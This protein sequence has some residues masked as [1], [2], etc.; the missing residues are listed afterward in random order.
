MTSMANVHI[1]ELPPDT[2]EALKSGARR[3]RRSL[4]AEIIDALVNH[5]QHL[6]QQAT[7]IERVE[8]VRRRW[9]EAFPDGFPPGLEPE[10]TIRRD[11]ERDDLR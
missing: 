11:R 3:H 9:R 4:N 10:T 5:A 7:L 8:E 6:E 2:L 1:R